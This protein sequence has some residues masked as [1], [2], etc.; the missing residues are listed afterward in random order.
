L[1]SFFFFFP[2]EIGSGKLLG[3]KPRS[4]WSLPPE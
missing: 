4:S 1:W 2:S 3:F